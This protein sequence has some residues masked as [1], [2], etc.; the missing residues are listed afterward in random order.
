MD[1]VIKNGI[2]VNADGKAEVDIGIEAGKIAALGKNL[3]GRKTIDASGKYL[4]PGGIDIHTHLETVFGGSQ[5]ADDFLSGHLGAIAGG[6]TSHINFCFPDPGQSLLATLAHWQQKVRSKS[7]IDYGFHLVIREESHLEE[8]PMLLEKGVSSIKCFLA[9]KD[10]V[11]IDEELF[12]KTVEKAKEH[13]LLTM[14][15]AENGNIIDYLVKKALANHFISPIFHARTR[16]PELESQSIHFAASVASMLKA[17]LYIVHVSSEKGLEEIRRA[18]AEGTDLWAETCPQYLLFTERDLERKGHTPNLEDFEGAKWVCSPPLRKEEDQQALWEGLRLGLIDVV[19]T[20]HCSFHFLSQKTRGL[21]DFSKIPNG[22]P[23]IEERMALLFHYGCKQ[24]NLP[25]ERFVSLTAET[26]AF[27]FG[28]EGQK[29][30]LA[31]GYDADVVLWDPNKRQVLSVDS[32]HIQLDYNLYEGFAIEGGPD[33][34]MLRGK[35]IYANGQFFVEQ[36]NGNYLFR[37]SYKH[38]LNHGTKS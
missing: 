34:V 29:G 17:P 7:L 11:Q 35:I 6:T 3:S 4:I 14:V 16:P 20:D 33:M 32:H 22:V 23:G 12:F 30:R 10:T 1:V 27:L 5:T 2:L 31:E 36:G 9:Y 37:S 26:P 28:L 8:L 18:K 25:M 21:S 24:R 19:S 15:H 13:G 38:S